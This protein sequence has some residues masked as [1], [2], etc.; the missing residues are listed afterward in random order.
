MIDVIKFLGNVKDLEVVGSGK[1]RI[2][3][4]Q[5]LQFGKCASMFSMRNLGN[6]QG[7][8]LGMDTALSV[9]SEKSQF[10]S[11]TQSFR[12]HF[13]YRTISE[14]TVWYPPPTSVFKATE[15]SD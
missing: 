7:H 6:F 13:C 8:P 12:I 2:W 15:T 5:Y 14:Q 10:P 4:R 9:G 3:C 11:V 1:G